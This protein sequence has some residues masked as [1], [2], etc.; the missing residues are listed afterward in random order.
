[1]FGR[2]NPKLFNDFNNDLSRPI[3]RTALKSTGRRTDAGK[4][5]QF[6]PLEPAPPD[7]DEVDAFCEAIPDLKKLERYEQRTLSRQNRAIRD[8]LG[9]LP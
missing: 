6:E 1:V 2:T 4:S 3:R 9:M 5:R 8:F 7:R